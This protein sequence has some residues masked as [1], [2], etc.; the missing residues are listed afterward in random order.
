MA[1]SPP[2]KY[3][4][5]DMKIHQ[6]E[7]ATTKL[8]TLGGFWQAAMLWV[9]GP[10]GCLRM[11]YG[12]GPRR[13]EMFASRTLV[14]TSCSGSHVAHRCTH[15]VSSRGQSRSHVN[16]SIGFSLPVQKIR[17][18]MSSSKYQPAQNVCIS[19][20]VSE[21]RPSAKVMSSFTSSSYQT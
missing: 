13:S 12:E 17:N 10:C 21:I 9:A 8:V 16:H 2:I 18:P 7:I 6:T 20:H 4:R 1:F 14:L 11:I 5:A 19:M 15:A 3:R